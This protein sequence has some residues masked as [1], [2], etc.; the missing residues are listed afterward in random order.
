V[1][2]AFIPIN[3]LF[4][5]V[6]DFFIV[7]NR[8]INWTV[9]MSAYAFVLTS[10]PLLAVSVTYLKS[11]PE[12][13]FFRCMIGFFLYAF[14]FSIYMASDLFYPIYG[15]LSALGSTLVGVL[16]YVSV[17]NNTVNPKSVVYS[18]VFSSI[19]VMIPLLL[20]QINTERFAQLSEAVGAASLLYGY[21]NPRA[22]GW[23][24]TF[25]LSLLTA[26]LSTQPRGSSVRPIFLV[27]VTIS[28]MTLFWSGSRGGLFAFAVSIFI[29]FSLSKTKNY[30]GTL[31]VLLCLA[32]GGIASLFLHLPSEAF[33]MFSRISQNLE[34]GSIFAASSGRIIL[35]QT[36]I[37]YIIER[38]FTGYGY[39][40]HKNLVGFSYG[41]A[42]NI[43]L[44]FWLSFGV[45]VGTITILIGVV[46]WV[47]ALS[48]FRKANDQYISA[49]FCSVTTLLV[50]SMVSGPYARTFPLLLFAIGSGVLLGLRS[51]KAG[52][53]IRY[54]Q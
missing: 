50:Y 16:F 5:P 1:V 31:L 42:H 3:M 49:L 54:D 36:T 28:A 37:S 46:F 41:S 35:W 18:L 21:E 52:W 26:Y 13:I 29:V 32:V 33:G 30:T 4:S 14:P 19:F 12:K 45:I 43:I 40:P 24:S 23:V 48:F 17:R 51:L 47:M 22:V 53:R 10:M 39:L 15:L 27:L 9:T 11:R 34:Q 25:S 7:Q 20:V 44:D 38:P 6:F 8:G 2:L